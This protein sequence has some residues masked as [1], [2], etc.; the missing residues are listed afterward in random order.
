LKPSF[1]RSQADAAVIA[2]DRCNNSVELSD[3]NRTS[4]IMVFINAAIAK[5]APFGTISE[6]RFD[7]IFGGNVPFQKVAEMR[8]RRLPCSSDDIRFVKGI[9]MFVNG[10]FSQL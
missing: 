9:K 5:Y 1:R 7:R 8:S 10:G 2:A 6:G 4:S 3:K